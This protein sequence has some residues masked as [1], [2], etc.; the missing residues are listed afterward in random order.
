MGHMPVKTQHLVR[1]INGSVRRQCQ[2]KTDIYRSLIAA[3][4][5]PQHLFPVLLRIDRFSF[6]V[7][8]QKSGTI[9]HGA[10]C[11]DTPAFYGSL[12]EQAVFAGKEE[13]KYT[14]AN[15][16]RI[17][18]LLPDRK[19]F[20]FSFVLRAG[21]F[22][23]FSFAPAYQGIFPV[24]P[25]IVPAF[26]PDFH[27][28]PGCRL[29][30]GPRQTDCYFLSASRFPCEAVGSSFGAVFSLYQHVSDF[31]VIHKQAADR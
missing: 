13:C 31:P 1:G 14:V 11:K 4:Y 18:F 24:T 27:A 22:L 26:K 28:L 9:Q 19:S 3:G 25:A 16:Q 15:K 21:A 5:S 6:P 8:R 23:C 17:L 20:R 30:T 29:F 10:A 12:P 7:S 2:K